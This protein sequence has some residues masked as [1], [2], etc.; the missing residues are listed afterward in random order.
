MRQEIQTYRACRTPDL[1]FR[2]E[3]VVSTADSGGNLIARLTRLRNIGV[4]KMKT[5]NLTRRLARRAK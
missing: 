2:K 1:L 3:Q 4:G 5:R